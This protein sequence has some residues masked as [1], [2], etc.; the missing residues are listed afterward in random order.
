MITTIFNSVFVYLATSIDEIPILFILY[1]KKS[2]QGKARTI[3]GMYFLG[4][5][6]LVT[7]GILG[8]R[9]LG[10]FIPQHILGLLGLVP[11]VMG[12]QT[13]V[14]AE[15]DDELEEA[16]E[17]MKKQTSLSLQILA[18]TIGLGADDL[19]VYVPL[20]TTLV[21]TELIIML[22]V[23]AI[24]TG[25]LCFISYR[26]TSFKVLTGFIEKYERL[27]VGTIF[28]VVGFSIM[29]ESGTF[30]WMASL[31]TGN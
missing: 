12:V 18:I 30:T 31:L 1:T 21:S 11:F 4:T 23:F 6:I 19:A 16:E 14:K 28:I 26:M 13:L 7:A 2:N 10:L 5:F 15:E 17:A 9:G 24:A 8:A 27:I 29:N 3:T 20:F 25:L 22:I